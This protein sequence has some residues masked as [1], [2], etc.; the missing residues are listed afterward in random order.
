MAWAATRICGSD[1]DFTGRAFNFFQSWA[2]LVDD[3]PLTWTAV[4]LVLFVRSGCKSANLQHLANR[5]VLWFSNCWASKVRFWK[6]SLTWFTSITIRFTAFFTWCFERSEFTLGTLKRIDY[7]TWKW[8]FSDY[9]SEA[10]LFA[11]FLVAAVV[12]FITDF[13]FDGV[14]IE[15]ETVEWSSGGNYWGG[16]TSGGGGCWAWG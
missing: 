4:I 6:T 1:L 13:T 7:R 11:S 14:I 5:V 15:T 3:F 2:F 9:A 16:G 8:F 12:P 10:L